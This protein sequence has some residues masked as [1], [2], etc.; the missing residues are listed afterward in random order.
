MEGARTLLIIPMYNCESQIVRVLEKSRDFVLEFVDEVILIDNQSTDKTLVNATQG[1]LSYPKDTSVIQNQENINLGGSLKTG[2][3]YAIENNFQFVIV[4]HG[5]DQASIENLRFAFSD[6]HESDFD[7]LIGAR[8]HKDSVLKGYSIVRKIGNR[9]LNLFCQLS[10]GRRISDLIA[11]LNLIR[12]ESLDINEILVFP[13][14]LTFDVHLLLHSINRKK[15]IE[16]FPMT[17]VEEDQVSNA[18]VLRQGASIMHLFV[19]YFFLRSKV[20]QFPSTTDSYASFSVIF[21]NKK[22]V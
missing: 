22:G 14:N 10:T 3:M 1:I 20:F 13:N 15:N 11:G 8:F 19:R 16:F 18:K 7:L 17:W 6:L 2:F 9:I 5:D 4:L 12:L 21:S